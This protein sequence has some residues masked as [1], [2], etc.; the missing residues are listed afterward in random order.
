MKP[1]VAPLNRRG[2]LLGA[3]AIGAAPLAGMFDLP[4]ETHAASTPS[5]GKATASLG[6]LINI[7][8]TYN[9]CG[10]AAIAEV[11]AYW[12]ISRSQAQTQAALRVDGPVVGM[13]LYGIP[14][15]AGS[16]GLRTLIGVGG[17]DRLLKTLIVKRFPVI[18]HDV[19]SLSDS[20]GHW[21]PVE[22]YDDAQGIF[23]TSDPLLGA[24]YAIPYGT[25]DRL[26]AQR[27]YTFIVLYPAA[28]QAALS[29]A[30]TAGG[31]NK[32]AAFKQNLALL[33]ASRLDA[34][35][36]SAPA[37]TAS[38]Y[39]ALAM[40]WDEAQLGNRTAARIYLQQATRVGANPVEVRWITQEIG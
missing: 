20:T 14:S 10:P 24:G 21:R 12:G 13:T 40:A 32:V 31:W 25:F 22:A 3:L 4:P 6:P 19:V 26:W 8:Q 34:S 15:Y 39:R 11:L 5:A 2:F 29:A 38:A 7:P 1:V 16:L 36:A 30:V 37:S 18:V 28:R 33:A 27:G 17:T 9:N 23:V 35:P